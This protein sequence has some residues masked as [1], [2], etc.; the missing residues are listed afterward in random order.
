MKLTDKISLI[1]QLNFI[2]YFDK[3]DSLLF[4]ELLCKYNCFKP[5]FRNNIKLLYKY[6]QNVLLWTVITKNLQDI[7]YMLKIGSTITINTLNDL[8]M[9]IPQNIKKYIFERL[10]VTSE[11]IDNLI[12]LSAKHNIFS[13]IQKYLNK[14]KCECIY[15]CDT[16]YFALTLAVQHQNVKICEYLLDKVC[17]TVDELRELL[18]NAF[19][20]GNIEIIEYIWARSTIYLG[21]VVKYM[22]IIYENNHIDLMVYMIKHYKSNKLI[23]NNFSNMFNIGK[24]YDVNK[25]RMNAIIKDICQRPFDNV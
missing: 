14:I 4:Y 10:S 17:C 2:D 22:L 15:E 18:C 9:D 12:I 8:T 21:D 13:T 25:K 19:E 23:M 7:Q 20:I 11:N 24:F 1:L 16:Q 5:I 3:N 6:D